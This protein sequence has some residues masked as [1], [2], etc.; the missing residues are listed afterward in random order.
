[1]DHGV[2]GQVERPQHVD[3]L[4]A[5]DRAVELELRE[6]ADDLAAHP[7]ADLGAPEDDH[8]LA[9]R[10][11]DDDVAA[12]RQHHATSIDV[13]GNANVSAEDVDQIAVPIDDFGVVVPLGQRRTEGRDGRQQ[14]GQDQQQAACAFAPGDAEVFP[15]A[16]ESPYFP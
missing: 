10:P 2:V 8:D 5:Y 1:M 16:H 4:V 7:A 12:E 11:L 9:D 13:L 14:Q 15:L 6:H 3:D